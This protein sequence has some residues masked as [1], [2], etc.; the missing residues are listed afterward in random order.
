M[1][2]TAD[3]DLDRATV[4]WQHT[5]FL[6]KPNKL[7]SLSEYYPT[8]GL[9]VLKN[10]SPGLS[11]RRMSTLVFTRYM[12]YEYYCLYHMVNVLC[13]CGWVLCVHVR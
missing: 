6:T 9:I 11:I 10:R 2:G 5:I 3:V 12:I 4:G 8:Q 1:S 7:W 13:L